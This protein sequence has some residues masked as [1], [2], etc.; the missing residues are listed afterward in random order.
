MYFTIITETLIYQT[1]IKTLTL[2]LYYVSF[3]TIFKIWR[4]KKKT[5]IVKI[6]YLMERSEDR[7][8]TIST[9]YNEVWHRKLNAKEQRWFKKQN[10]KLQNPSQSGWKVSS[11]GNSLR[12]FYFSDN[13]GLYVTIP[14]FGNLSP[15]HLIDSNILHRRAIM[16]SEGV[17]HAHYMP[18][19]CHPHPQIRTI[20]YVSRHGQMSPSKGEC[21]ITPSW[22]LL[23]THVNIVPTTWNNSPISAENSLSVQNPSY[24]LSPV[25]T[26]S[27]SCNPFHSFHLPPCFSIWFHKN[28]YVLFSFLDNENL[29]LIYS[30]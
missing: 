12:I 27:Q 8:N 21:K 29:H 1:V 6:L 5:M 18:A 13:T 17:Q 26:S 19:A 11:L 28:I 3:S 24:M 4:N 15:A 20:K 16:C 23:Y 2:T 7:I 9:W 25:W 30:L 10:L 14:Q 22:E